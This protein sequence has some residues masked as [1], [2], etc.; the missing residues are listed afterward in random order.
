MHYGL[1]GAGRSSDMVI[2]STARTTPNPSSLK[3]DHAAQAQRL[4]RFIEGM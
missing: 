4:C 3:L 2:L 1:K